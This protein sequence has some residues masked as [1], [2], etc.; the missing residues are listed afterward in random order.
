L[1]NTTVEGIERDGDDIVGVR[2]ARG[3]I[4]TDTVICT[5]GPWSRSI[6]EMAGVELPVE[7]L[8]RQ[9]V[10]TEAVDGLAPG[11]PFTIDFST[12]F[13]FHGEGRGLLLGMSDPDE[14]PGFKL[15]RSQDWLPRLGDAIE[16]RAPEISR[17]GIASGW[18]GLYEVTPDCN[19]LIGE[20]SGV[21]RFLYATGF[22]GH[23]F[24]M[25]PAVG[26]V[27]RDLY[28]GTAPVIDVSALDV[29]RFLSGEIRRELN[30]V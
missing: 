26:E 24:L 22:S 19:A 8:R 29:D 10:T 17:F 4:R 15:Q 13:Y 30:I 28:H 20:A 23:G 5:A 11:T 21:S 1:R 14:T 18:A 12:T 7:P 27:I 25:G 6:G 16:K 9:I 3:T 2:T